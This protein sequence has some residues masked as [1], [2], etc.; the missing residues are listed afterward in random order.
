M[1]IKTTSELNFL[2]VSLEEV[3]GFIHV[4]GE[5]L[6]EDDLLTLHIKAATHT[7]EVLGWQSIIQKT[8]VLYLR[9]YPD[10]IYLPYPPFQALNSVLSVTSIK[11][12]PSSDGENYTA[13]NSSNYGLNET[14]FSPY[15]YWK[16]NASFPAIFDDVKAIEVIYN[17]GYPDAESV[18]SEIKSVILCLVSHLYDNR[19]LVAPVQLHELPIAM[20][21]M[22]ESIRKNSIA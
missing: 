9:D 22:I 8:R 19:D 2:P 14:S 7:L 15:I 5:N 20:N 3:K 18:P 16:S 1:N 12:L 6:D 4:E 21:I 13:L 10:K 11:Y 17:T